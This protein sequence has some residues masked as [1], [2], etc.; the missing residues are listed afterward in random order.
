MQ[1]VGASFA[2]VAAAVLIAQWFP[3]RKFPIY[4]G[5]T[6]TISCF[7]AGVIHYFFAIALTRYSWNEIYLGLALFGFILLI[8]SWLFITSPPEKERGVISLKQSLNL[9][10]HNKQMWLCSLAAAT[11]FGVLLAYAGLWYMKIQAYYSVAELQAVIISALI[12]AGIGSGTPVLGWLSNLVHSRTM[13]VHTTLA[14]GTMALL[15]GIYLPHFDINNLIII[16]VISFLIGFLLSGSM[17]FYTMVSEMANNAIRGV[18][19]SMLNTIVF[20][21][22]SIML[23]IPYLFIT[24]TSRDFFT[25]LWIFPFLVIFSLLLIY[26]IKD[27]YST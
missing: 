2:F 12:F 9:V 27:T 26:F 1:G 18:A 19:L 11:S 24:T 10:L 25:Y 14:L 23:F 3:K 17:L 16:K 21:L 5:L 7:S 15:A 6:Q 4:F 20:A 22:N 8:L 13:I